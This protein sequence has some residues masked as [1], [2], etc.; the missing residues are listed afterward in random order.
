MCGYEGVGF[1]KFVLKIPDMKTADPDRPP[2]KTFDYIHPLLQL[3]VALLIAAI[4]VWPTNTHSLL[5]LSSKWFYRSLLGM[6]MVSFV[7][8]AMVNEAAVQLDRKLRWEEQF[9]KRAFYQLLFG[10]ALPVIVSFLVAK[11]YFGWA[12]INIMTTLYSRHMYVAILG[13]PLIINFGYMLYYL[14]YFFGV[15]LEVAEILPEGQP[16]PDELIFQQREGP[17]KM[18]VEEIAYVF[19][20]GKDTT[21][22]P[23]NG[24]PVCLKMT[25][26]KKV[27]NVLSADRFC[28]VNKS[29]IISQSAYIKHRRIDRGLL[30]FLRPEATEPVVVSRQRI[31][32]VLNL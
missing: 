9:A 1:C 25:P 30:L 7:W 32:L 5:G 13:L 24:A 29:Y 2:K 20:R 27:A 6:F 31:G 10:W 4:L 23:H 15:G 14:F 19:V 16:Y 22:Q 11:W 18:R 26:L 28:Q 8:L 3:P 12:H 21:I 17:V